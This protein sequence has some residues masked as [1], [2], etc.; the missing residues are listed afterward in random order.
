MT[1]LLLG[2]K[3]SANTLFHF[4]NSLDNLENILTNEFRPHY[5]LEDWSP[6]IGNR[7][8]VAIPM[9]CFCDIPLAQI[10]S[11]TRYYGEYAIGL[12]KEWGKKNKIAP[13]LYTYK[14]SST[15]EYL[16]E[17]KKHFITD[18]KKLREV[19]VAYNYDKL[20]Q[21]TKP[22]EGE[23]IKNGKSHGL[24]RFYD[25][26]EWRFV[27]KALKVFNDFLPLMAE[28]SFKNEAMRRMYNSVVE[29]TKIPFEPN[30]IRYIVVEK[31]SQI[32]DIV[33]KI[34]R[35]KEKYSRE[36]KNLLITRIISM[37]QIRDDF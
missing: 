34:E 4:T 21:F 8:Q 15:A 7:Y 36:D 17:I 19:P 1:K 24:V 37:E 18:I 14:G 5:S 29:K 35:I 16:A 2:A 33:G 13:V 31:E 12:S 28:K 30:D 25:E 9:V 26:R 20:I 6:I 27:P 3:L 23:L 22:Y 10:H 32:L 11:H